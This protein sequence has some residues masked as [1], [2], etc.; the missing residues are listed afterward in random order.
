MA[1]SKD[2]LNQYGQYGH[3]LLAIRDRGMTATLDAPGL[4]IALR[5]AGRCIAT[6]APGVLL[7][8]LD[9]IVRHSR[10]IET[11]FATFYQEIHLGDRKPYS[12]RLVDLAGVAIPEIFAVGVEEGV[13]VGEMIAETA[14]A[15][16]ISTS[17]IEE[18]TT[19]MSVAENVT[20]ETGETV[21]GI[22]SEDVGL[23]LVGDH[24]PE[25]TFGIREI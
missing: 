17:E 16:E 4:E 11:P 19:G 3:G 9:R 22:A 1:I 21:T 6:A 7:R 12:M 24:L 14:V 8:N 2:S 23:H 15:I 10:P 25:G 13:E 18:T 5:T 20:A